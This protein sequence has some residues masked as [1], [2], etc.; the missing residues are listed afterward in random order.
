MEGDVRASIR[1]RWEVAMLHRGVPWLLAIVLLGGACAAPASAPAQAPAATSAP[2]PSSA[3]AAAGA[4]APSVPVASASPAAAVAPDRQS[5][6]YGYNPILP[7]APEFIA[8]ERGYFAEQGLDV[9]FVPFDSGALMIAPASA[10]Q[11]DVITAVPSPSLFNALARDV[12]LHAVAAQSLSYTVLLVRQ[13][14]AASGQVRTLQDLKGRRVSFNVEGSP[15]DY[16]L[17]LALQKNGLSLNDVDVQRVVNTDLAAALAN[18]AVDAG[19]VP[20]PLPTLIENRGVG[21]RALDVQTLAG[22]QEAGLMVVGPSLLSRPDAVTTRFVVAHMQGVRDYLAAIQDGKVSDP[23]MLAILSQWT[24]IPTETIGQAYHSG[25]EP[26]GRIDLDDLN[27]QQDFWEH[28]GL[29]PTKADMAKFVEYK[30]LEA[31]LPRLR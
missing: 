30:Y 20:E 9:E 12:N 5:L 1:A 15:V 4:P 3:P 2:P 8:Q 25:T 10:G 29:V 18:S 21:T 22:R 7:G 14:L 11:L 23:Q 26:T 6:K 13:D 28:E 16:T 24:R 17:R 19:V 27:R 31:A